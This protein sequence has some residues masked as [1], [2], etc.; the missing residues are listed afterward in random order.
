MRTAA[1]LAVLTTVCLAAGGGV[2]IDVPFVEQT[3]NAC[4]AANAAMLLRYWSG[5]GARIE[6]AD[7]SLADLHAELYSA[8]ERGAL[9]SA[10]ASL[11]EAAGLR[12]FT[13]EGRFEDLSE[14]LAK[15][16]PLLVC[17]KPRGQSR[18]HYALAVGLEP[19]DDVVLLNDPARRKLSKMDRKEF[20]ASWA[21]A[22]NWTLL[23]TPLATR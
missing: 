16:R 8:E 17:L 15:G 21:G 3:R 19:A 12:T 6:R 1:A 2:W 11:L 14:H 9:G 4:G 18:L 7:A 20:L 22:G 10:L 13:F 23:A 5:Q